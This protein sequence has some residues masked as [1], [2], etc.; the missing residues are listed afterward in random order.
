MSFEVILILLLAL[1]FFAQWLD[2]LD[3]EG[4]K[5]QAKAN[6]DAAAAAKIKK[7]KESLDEFIKL[8]SAD[9][10]NPEIQ[11]NLL[12]SMTLQG[13]PGGTGTAYAVVLATLAQNPDA[14]ILKQLALDAGRIHYDTVRGGAATLE[15]EQRI[16]NDIAV[17]T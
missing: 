15:D 2:N 11:S 8:F 16:M 1:I 14:V 4:K 5:R 3:R 13:K 12:A 6:Q 9:P 17:R 7:C 10:L